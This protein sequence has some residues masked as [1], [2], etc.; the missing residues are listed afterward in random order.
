MESKSNARL[1]KQRQKIN[2]WKHA[3][4]W[5]DAILKPKTGKGNKQGHASI[6]VSFLLPLSTFNTLP[7]QVFFSL[8][9]QI[10][11]Q[12]KQD[13]ITLKFNIFTHCSNGSSFII[14]PTTFL[15]IYQLSILF[16]SS[17]IMWY[18]AK[19]AF[20]FD[21]VPLVLFH[22]LRKYTCKRHSDAQVRRK[23]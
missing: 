21:I 17:N 8:Y 6:S 18:C 13:N 4:M 11:S 1:R 19:V 15:L 23:L 12:V 22:Q 16:F 7:F 10:R 20:S 5:M 2:T 14:S 3:I 9:C